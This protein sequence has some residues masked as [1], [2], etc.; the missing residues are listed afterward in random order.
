MRFIKPTAIADAQFVSSTAPETDFAAWNAAT[1]YTVGDSVIRTTTHRIY[2]RLIGGTTAT[3]PESDSVNWLD[4]GPT[5][6]W[7]MFDKAI[8]TVTSIATPLTVVI[9]PGIIDSLTLLDIGGSSV[10]VSMKDE[11]GGATVFSHSYPLPDRATV[12]NWFDYFFTDIVPQSTLTLTSLPPYSTCQLTVTVNAT[13]TARCGTLVVGRLFQIGKTLANPTVSII[14]YSRKETDAFGVT[15]VVE[16]TYA[17][18]IEA[19]F[20]FDSGAVDYVSR[21]LAGIRATPVMWLADD[22][23]I[24]ESLVAFGF[25]KD[26]G[27]NIQY[28]NFS[29]ASITIEGLT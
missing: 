7:A 25:Y 9:T 19:R 24:V 18:R 12:L 17:K 22:A 28:S 14:D 29:E 16:R 1:A 13:T 27:I 26:W 10:D 15:D 21:A 2:E 23:D 11:P 20:W 3:A 6:R 8:G 4:V 5:N